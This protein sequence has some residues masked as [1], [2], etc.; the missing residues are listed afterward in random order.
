LHGGEAAELNQGGLEHGVVVESRLAE[1][2]VN[3]PVIAGACGFSH[4]LPGFC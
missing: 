2:A 1:Q 3:R 4:G